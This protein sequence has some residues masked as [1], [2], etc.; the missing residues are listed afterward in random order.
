MDPSKWRS[1]LGVTKGLRKRRY[2]GDGGGR[3][4]GGEEGGGEG[5]GGRREVGTGEVA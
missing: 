2:R 3:G 4:Q 1:R 5:K